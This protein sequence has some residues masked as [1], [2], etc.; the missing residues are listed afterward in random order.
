MF[1]TE[2]FITI[3]INRA[4]SRALGSWNQIKILWPLWLGKRTQGCIYRLQA[5]GVTRGPYTLEAR[6]KEASKWH[7]QLLRRGNA[8]LLGIHTE[9]L[10]SRACT[11]GRVSTAPEIDVARV[12]SGVGLI[13]RYEHQRPV[14][15][16]LEIEGYPRILDRNVVLG[17]HYAQLVQGSD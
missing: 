4:G 12:N 1:L 11:D 13:C 15:G 14:P 16:V 17:P 9:N 2:K 7:A 10:D 8:A 3:K 6:K 5:V